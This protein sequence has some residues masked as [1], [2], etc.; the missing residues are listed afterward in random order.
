MC[1]LTCIYFRL[2]KHITDINCKAE[3]KWVTEM[4][5]ILI[6]K[7]VQNGKGVFNLS[8]LKIKPMQRINCAKSWEAAEFRC[9]MEGNSSTNYLRSLHYLTHSHICLPIFRSINYGKPRSTPVK[10]NVFSVH[11]MSVK[12]PWEAQQSAGRVCVRRAQRDSW[13]TLISPFQIFWVIN[14]AAIMVLMYLCAIRSK[15]REKPN[16]ATCSHPGIY[17]IH[18]RGNL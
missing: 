5:Y 12:S 1:I 2:E 6:E 7:M 10:W 8:F 9:E 18:Q 17:G 13:I 3:E 11:L 4:C 16:T 15:Q 14:F